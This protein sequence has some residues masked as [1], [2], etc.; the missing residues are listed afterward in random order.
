MGGKVK[1][2]REMA[3]ARNIMQWMESMRGRFVAVRHAA[4]VSHFPYPGD[5]G[6]LCILVPLCPVRAL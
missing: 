6:P 4:D 1:R 5:S 3:Y 2:E